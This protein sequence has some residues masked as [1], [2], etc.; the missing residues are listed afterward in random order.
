MSVGSSLLSMSALLTAAAAS[1]VAGTSA[2]DS[3]AASDGVGESEGESTNGS[4]VCPCCG[5]LSGFAT[6]SPPA[7]SICLRLAMALVLDGRSSIA[8]HVWLPTGYHWLAG[9]RPRLLS[10]ERTLHRARI[11][12]HRAS[13]GPA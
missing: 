13:L 3:L 11:T 6:G 4:S 1:R 9:K 8:N 10:I 7:L 12:S 5:A 2:T